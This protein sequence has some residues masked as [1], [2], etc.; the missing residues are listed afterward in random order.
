MSDDLPKAYEPQQV[1][2]R[3]YDFWQSLRLFE[4]PRQGA[5]YCIML[6][7]PNVTGTLHMG[8]AFQDTLMDILVRH[9]RMQNRR[10]LWQVGTDHAGIATQIVVEREL[11]KEGIGR[12]GIGREAFIQRVWEWKEK[13]G[14]TIIQQMMRLGCSADWS[15]QRFTLDPGMSQAVSTAFIRLYQ[16]GLIYRGKRLVNWDPVLETAL[17]D[18]EVRSEEED[19]FL[20]YLRYPRPDGKPPLIVATTRPETLFGDVAIAVH[21]EDSRYLGLHG[22]RVHVPIT[23]RAIPVIPDPFVD[24]AFGSGCVK[25]TPAHDFHD[26][27]VW[28]RL[29]ETYRLPLFRIL[30]L[31]GHLQDPVVDHRPGGSGITWLPPGLDWMA[32]ELGCGKLVPDEFLG[33]ERFEARQLVIERLTQ[34]GLIEKCVPHRLA[35]PRGDRSGAILEPMLTE[36]WYVRTRQLADR[37]IEAVECGK[38]QFAPAHWAKTYF[39]WMRS[40]QDWCIS[41]QLWWGHRI[42]AWST[43]DKTWYVGQSEAEVRSNHQLDASVTL[44]QDPD[45]LDTWFSSALWPFSTLGWPEASSDLDLYYPTEVLVT[46][47]DIIFFWVARMIM[48]GLYFRDDVPF[49]TVYVH[50]LVRDADGQKMSKSKG[51]VLDPLDLIDGIGLE[52][53]VEKRTQGLLLSHQAKAIE[54]ATKNEYPQGIPAFGTDAL[55]FTFAALASPGRDI[56]FSLGRIAG[57]RNFCNKLWNAGR[58]VGHYVAERPSIDAADP[59]GT[60]AW[61][62]WIVSRFETTVTEAE[63]ALQEYRFDE[64]ARTLYDFTWNEFCGWYLEAAK[65]VLAGHSPPDDRRRNA[66]RATLVQVYSRLLR[67][68]HPVVP[69]ITEELWQKLPAVREDSTQSIM[70]APYPQPVPER[71]NPDLEQKIRSVQEIVME[72]RRLRSAYGIPDNRRMRASMVITH[73]SGE[74]RDFI[75]QEAGTIQMLA[76]LETIEE[77]HESA[78]MDKKQ[79]TVVTASATFWIRLLDYIDLEKERLRITKE[80]H[81]SQNKAD[82]LKIRLNHA[83]FL[84]HAPADLIRTEQE[85]LAGLE[86]HCHELEKQLQTLQAQEE[87]TA[88]G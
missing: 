49:R 43:A 37:A 12:T 40:I 67:L 65:M 86:Q 78:G 75:R 77:S 4:A 3:I 58:F 19:G 14:E 50:A 87:M 74:V 15:R 59:S 42:P 1:E 76:H 46:G 52:S 20:W 51:N 68:L 21:P 5:P 69:F 36:Q 2:K 17:S 22:K 79:V 24:P 56:R 82:Q 73:P 25:I 8:H 35:I 66:T 28:E 7:P 39:D 84:E 13:S 61:D 71:I 41:R 81:G 57:Y 32:P 83:G 88:R 54:R 18:L 27:E 10:V 11:Q 64:L 72:I 47:F 62:R 31:T 38:V 48:V 29:H 6:P 33:R 55:R 80:L 34:D 16:D 70:T 60:T 30:D 9:A 63:A 26:F 53:L 23:G 44:V 45:V 85:R